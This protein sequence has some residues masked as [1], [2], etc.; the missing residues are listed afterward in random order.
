VQVTVGRIGKPHGIRG[1]VTIEVRTDEPELRFAPGTT[2]HRESGSDLIVSD[3]HW[4]SG[5][6]LLKFLGVD[7]RSAAEELRNSILTVERPEDEVPQENDEYYDSNLIGCQVQTIAGEVVGQVIDVLHLPSQEVL[8]V[9]TDGDAATEYLIPF[10]ESIV[11]TVDVITKI[12]T[13]DPPEGLLTEDLDS[14][15]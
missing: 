2:L 3:F 7:S 9:R 11:P 15:D 6:V 10:V 8:V 12:I 1:E 14:E 13:V 5:R 4:H